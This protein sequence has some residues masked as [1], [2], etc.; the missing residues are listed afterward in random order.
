MDILEGI[1]YFLYAV[2]HW[3]V[4]VCLVVS[5]CLAI[6]L[7]NLVPWLTGLQGVVLA[8]LGLIPGVIWDEWGTS[9]QSKKIVKPS[10]TSTFVAS[11]SAIIIGG[12]WG[13][14]SATSFH[15]FC[16]GTVIFLVAGWVWSWYVNSFKHWFTKGR[17][18]LCVVLAALSYPIAALVAQNSL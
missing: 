17:V 14:F 7:V 5:S 4:I 18:F 10:E 1:V 3:R 12:A 15:S 13:V 16:A 6:V 8:A 11:A 2:F 9:K